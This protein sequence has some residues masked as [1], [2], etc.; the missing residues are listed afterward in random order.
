M[1][2]EEK[3][4][5]REL[6]SRHIG[7]IAI[8]GTIGTGLFLGAGNS[9]K[10]AGPSIIFIYAI[11]GFFI[12]LLMR[13]LGELLVSD[14]SQTTFV[15]F[16][17]KYLG[18]RFGFV[19]GWTYW[20]GWI[21]TAMAELTAAGKYMSFWFKDTP[22][23]IWSIVFLTLLFFANIIT[24]KAFGE[25]EFW[26]SMIKIVAILAIIITGAVLVTI[27]FKT[28]DGQTSSIAN[29]WNT[30]FFANN[31]SGFL[32]AFQM[33]FFA[34][35]GIEFIGMTAA[36]AKNPQITIPRSV[37]SVIFRIVIFYIGA[38]IAIMS[39]YPWQNYSAE[40]SPFVQVFTGIGI[41][42]AAHIV[43]FVV[44]TA[45]SSAL[46]SS[47][48]STGRMLYSLNQE[49]KNWLG[50]LSNQ[51]VPL[52]AIISSSIL[53]GLAA[54]INYVFPNNA[55][56]MV[57]S[58]AAAT[59]LFIY[60]ILMIAHLKYRKS[61]DFKKTKKSFKLPGAPV[62]NWLTLA[63]FIFIFAILVAHPTTLWPALVALFWMIIIA[64]I[65]FVTIKKEA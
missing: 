2:N 55:F 62:T 53:I 56:E 57:T 26:F 49:K 44:L 15:G 18:K 20:F 52:N 27:G 63:F 14:E 58:A 36:E 38:L 50:Q 7:M 9:I 45:A 30:G 46:N 51:H 23:W 40:N 11:V 19:V 16:I 41:S 42:S 60:S 61:K 1:K 43:N 10:T 59:F 34:F 13:A 17:D 33:A 54:L 24:V 37:N 28:G 48:F 22:V 39:I 25:L 29:I 21:V 47:I 12:F 65:S 3:N 31:G 8:G 32:I 4:L 6:S 35:V 64:A 5:K